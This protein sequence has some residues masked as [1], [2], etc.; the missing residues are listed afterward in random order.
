VSLTGVVVDTFSSRSE[1]STGGLSSSLATA[2]SQT[3]IY[4]SG[5][6]EKG[7]YLF[8]EKKE[9]VEKGNAKHC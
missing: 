6:S 5:V 2:S 4:K 8:Q 9:T 3:I 1:E 7:I